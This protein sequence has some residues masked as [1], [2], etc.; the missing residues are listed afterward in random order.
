ME[1]TYWQ[2]QEAGK[3]LFPDLEWSR[4]ENKQ[5]AGKLL[6]IGGNLHGFAA[7]AEGF[8][9]AAKAGIGTTRIVLPDALR[10]TVGRMLENGEYAPS[11][12]S[13]SFS[14]K[15]LGEL[16]TCASWADGTLLAGDLGRNSETAI[17][18]ETF[19]AKY[20]GLVT[21]TKDAVDYITAAPDSVL[22]RDN[23]LLVLSL[24]QLQRLAVAAKSTTAVTLGM[25]LLH[26]VEWLHDFTSRHAPY[27]VVKHHNVILAA[28]NG[29]VV[30]TRLST[31]IPVWRVA[32]AAHVSVWWLQNPGRAYEGIATGIVTRAAK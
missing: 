2:R 31:D 19:L 23:T 25:D 14:Q 8:A 28:V 5:Q 32:F 30:S 10:K 12:P 1:R 26:L 9:E 13:G 21:L 20:S 3:P 29:R 22:H 18:L 7:P 24:S 11:T 15:A 4:P 16:L 6:I 17:L 27:I